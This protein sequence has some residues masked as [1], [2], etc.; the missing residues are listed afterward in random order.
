VNE[1]EVDEVEAIMATLKIYIDFV[2]WRV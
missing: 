1:C 2:I